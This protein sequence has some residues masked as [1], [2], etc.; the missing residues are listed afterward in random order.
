MNL[1]A[2]PVNYQSGG[3][4]CQAEVVAPTDDLAILLQNNFATTYNEAE[5]F[6][7]ASR[8][9]NIPSAA[10]GF[11]DS[12]VII[13]YESLRVE[14]VASHIQGHAANTAIRNVDLHGIKVQV[15]G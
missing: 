6:G 15:G 13:C 9:A 8:A 3:V 4:D 5:T 2:V 11:S 7:A 1:V 10:A 12:G 14:S